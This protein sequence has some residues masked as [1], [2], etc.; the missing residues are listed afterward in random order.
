MGAIHRS[1]KRQTDRV[2]RRS[3]RHWK[4]PKCCRGTVAACYKPAQALAVS[5]TTLAR[6][7]NDA[8]KITPVTQTARM[9]NHSYRAVTVKHN[10]AHVTVDDR[11]QTNSDIRSATDSQPNISE[12]LKVGIFQLP[13]LCGL[14]RSRS[15][16]FS[17]GNSQKL[18]LY[19]A[20]WS[21][22]FQPPILEFPDTA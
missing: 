12:H 5:L 11:V 9:A 19:W 4:R 15:A 22:A 20:I 10:G 17:T 18:D 14:I 8:A 21:S 7:R 6:N 2:K 16:R 13:G 3:K 1:S